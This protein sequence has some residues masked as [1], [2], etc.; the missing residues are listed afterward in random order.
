MIRRAITT[1]RR[2]AT[3]ARAAQLAAL[4][5][6]SALD[7]ACIG[8]MQYGA[9]PTAEPLTDSL[10]AHLQAPAAEGAQ[11]PTPYA[12]GITSSSGNAGGWWL[13]G[14]TLLAALAGVA[15]LLPSKG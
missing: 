15:L 11:A 8:H 2:W 7:A 6:I 14:I 5:D 1:L 4:A 13:A 3:Q 9:M 10:Y 12:S